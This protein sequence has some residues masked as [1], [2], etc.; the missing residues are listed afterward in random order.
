MNPP[1][2]YSEAELRGLGFAHVGRDVRLDRSVRLFG[3]ERISIGDHCRIDSFCILSAGAGGI[4]IGRNV[5]VAA[6]CAMVGRGRIEL[7]DFANLSQ[8]CSI[9]SSSDDY[10]GAAMT[11]PT[12]PE[13]FTQVTHAPVRLGRHVIMGCGSVVLPGVTIG[14]GAAMGALTLIR[15]DVPDFAIMAGNP[16]RQLR[17]RARTMLELEQAYLASEAA[18][19]V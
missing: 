6:Y 14:I 2:L 10:T 11:N 4:A 18:K 17:E 9:F 12:I 13:E 5:H 1:H 7:G 16:A 8:R 15:H 3:I 19:L